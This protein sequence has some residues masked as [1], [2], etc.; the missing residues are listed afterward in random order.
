MIFTA[1]SFANENIEDPNL[2]E[3]EEMSYIDEEFQKSKLN[4]DFELIKQEKIFK[5]LVA[6][7]KEN[8]TKKDLTD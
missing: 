8:E 7:L 1:K 6:Q 5:A 2:I 3:P 4:F